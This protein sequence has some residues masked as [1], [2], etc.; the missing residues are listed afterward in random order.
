MLS[1]GDQCR[2]HEKKVTELRRLV[3][4]EEKNP[5]QKKSSRTIQLNYRDKLVY[6]RHEVRMTSLPA[7]RASYI[8]SRLTVA[9]RV[10]LYVCKFYLVQS[11]LLIFVL[12][13][14]IFD[15]RSVTSSEIR[16]V[17]R[18]GYQHSKLDY[19]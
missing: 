9:P 16:P 11:V 12:A 15:I 4:E 3:S 5:P 19:W 7:T 10:M 8:L 18:P 14:E 13:A 1:Q 6:L 2:A 17:S